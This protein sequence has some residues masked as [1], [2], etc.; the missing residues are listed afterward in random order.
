[1]SEKDGK[2]KLGD[3]LKSVVS[4]GVSAASMGEEAVKG[5]M[6]NAK[7][8]KTE[9]IGQAKNEL[10]SW[11]DKIDLSKEIDR[12]LEDYDLEVNAKVSFKKKKSKKDETT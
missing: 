6:E 12:V 11:L 4:T 7:N 5:I 3:I 8:A 10:K 9:L 2:G 1:M